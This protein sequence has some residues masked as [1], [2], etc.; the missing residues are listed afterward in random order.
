MQDNFSL[1]EL[2]DCFEEVSS[3]PPN[4][5]IN[6]SAIG[7]CVFSRLIQKCFSF[8]V[9]KCPWFSPRDFIV[10]LRTVNHQLNHKKGDDTIYNRFS[11]ESANSSSVEWH[12]RLAKFL[13]A[14]SFFRKNKGQFGWI[15]CNTDQYILDKY[16]LWDVLC[17]TNCIYPI[18][19]SLSSS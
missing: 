3:I 16:D 12:L 9:R 5:P 13:D 1:A 4:L 18:I 8:G 11:R 15:L 6:K 7:I 14:F 17:K 2:I 10:W 19:S